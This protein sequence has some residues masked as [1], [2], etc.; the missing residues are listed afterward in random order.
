MLF[1][2]ELKDILWNTK[3]DKQIIKSE[4]WNVK[5]VLFDEPWFKFLK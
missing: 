5:L 4:T 3:G 1:E 2:V